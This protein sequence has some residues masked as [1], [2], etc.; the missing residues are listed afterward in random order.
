MCSLGKLQPVPLV[1]GQWLEMEKQRGQV[2]H[3]DARLIGQ[4][5]LAD[6]LLQL[7]SCLVHHGSPLR[8]HISPCDC[9]QLSETRAAA[10]LAYCPDLKVVRMFFLLYIFSLLNYYWS[11]CRHIGTFLFLITQHEP[12]LICVRCDD[13]LPFTKLFKTLMLSYKH[14]WKSQGFLCSLSSF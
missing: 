6:F 10:T 2:K 14:N 7:P 1:V 5:N 12:V 11:L 8:D 3:H 4:Q 13:S 9:C